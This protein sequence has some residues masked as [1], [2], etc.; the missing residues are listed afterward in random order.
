MAVFLAI[1]PRHL[2]GGAHAGGSGIIKLTGFYSKRETIKGEM[3]ASCESGNDNQGMLPCRRKVSDAGAVAREAK[4]RLRKIV[5][6]SC[7][8]AS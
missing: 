3:T 5:P 1:S 2:R 7:R 8:A 4:P 6:S